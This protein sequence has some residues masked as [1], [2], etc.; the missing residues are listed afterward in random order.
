MKPV[1]NAVDMFDIPSRIAAC[2][3]AM[4]TLSASADFGLINYSYAV[5]AFEDLRLEWS[6]ILYEN[7]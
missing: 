7:D 5:G 6:N 4:P 2:K 3:F 1:E